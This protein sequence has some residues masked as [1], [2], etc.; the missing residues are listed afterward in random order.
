MKI[1]TFSDLNEFLRGLNLIVGK[2]GS[3]KTL[4]ATMLAFAEYGKG[5]KVYSNYPLNFPHEPITNVKVLREA[6]D[7]TILI[8]E[9]YEMA[10]A[11]R[12]TSIKN[13][14]ISEILAKA[15][16]HR[17]RYIFIA[18]YYKTVDVRIREH[19]DYIIRPSIYSIDVRAKRP[20]K[21]KLYIL[22]RDDVGNLL[23]LMSVV[24]PIPEKVF[25]LYDTEADI[26]PFTL[27]EGEEKEDEKQKTIEDYV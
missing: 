10:D 2:Q 6:K 4:F 26:Y 1:R 16:K 3:G 5:R 17:L 20:K 21:L 8:D 24:L 7:G 12:S 19:A 15:R 23:P 18:Q 27:E 9:A 25:E 22:T 14:I 13:V 11:R